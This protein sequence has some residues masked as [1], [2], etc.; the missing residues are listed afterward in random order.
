MQKL[1]A[2]DCDMIQKDIFLFEGGYKHE[3]PKEKGTSNNGL[4]FTIVCF[5]VCL[6]FL[7]FFYILG[8]T[9]LNI[10][11]FL[12]CIIDLI[13]MLLILAAEL[14]NVEPNE[15]ESNEIV[16]EDLDKAIVR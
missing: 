3:M 1:G 7:T 15:Q 10:I 16:I 4:L 8:F 13:G 12:I 9:E 5:L 2:F 11:V 14:T 6:V